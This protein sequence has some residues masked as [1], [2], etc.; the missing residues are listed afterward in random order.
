MAVDDST[1]GATGD[2]WIMGVAE[3]GHNV[4]WTTGETKG[5][6]DDCWMTEVKGDEAKDG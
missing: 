5:E 4:D 6:E 1:K 2:G 3:G